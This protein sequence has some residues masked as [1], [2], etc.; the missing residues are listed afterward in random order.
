VQYAF[1]RHRCRLATGAAAGTLTAENI[2]SR[3]PASSWQHPSHTFKETMKAL[4]YEGPRKVTV[5]DMPEAKIERPTDVLSH[6]LPLEKALEGYDN[7]DARN[8]GWT[9]VVLKPA[10]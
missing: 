3:R 4:V 2:V 7:F 9:K 10:A 8:D 5:K 6:E 1:A